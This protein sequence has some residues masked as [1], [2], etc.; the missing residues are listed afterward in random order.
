MNV[1]L[2]E[3]GFCLTVGPDHSDL[4]YGVDVL[5]LTHVLLNSPPVFHV[6]CPSAAPNIVFVLHA[7]HLG[8]FL[9]IGNGRA[10]TNL[11]DHTE[12]PY[13]VHV[14]DNLSRL[15]GKDVLGSALKECVTLQS[16][17]NKLWHDEQWQPWRVFSLEGEEDTPQLVAFLVKLLDNF[18]VDKL[19]ADEPV[20]LAKGYEPRHMVFFYLAQFLAARLACELPPESLA[21]IMSVASA[22][23][24]EYNFLESMFAATLLKPMFLPVR[25]RGVLVYSLFRGFHLSQGTDCTPPDTGFRWNAP[26]MA[27]RFDP[28]GWFGEEGNRRDLW[29]YAPQMGDR[30]KTLDTGANVATKVFGGVDPERGLNLLICKYLLS[31]HMMAHLQCVVFATMRNMLPCRHNSQCGDLHVVDGS[32]LK[33]RNAVLAQIKP[34]YESIKSARSPTVLLCTG[35][36]FGCDQEPCWGKVCT[37]NASLR[38]PYG[39]QWSKPWAPKSNQAPNTVVVEMSMSKSTYM[40]DMIDISLDT[41]SGRDALKRNICTLVDAPYNWQDKLK[42]F[43][44]PETHLGM[45]LRYSPFNE[46]EFTEVGNVLNPQE[47][48]SKFDVKF[49]KHDLDKDLTYLV[50]GTNGNMPMCH[51]TLALSIRQ[52]VAF[53]MGYFSAEM[54]RLLYGQDELN[55]D[56]LCSNILRLSTQLTPKGNSTEI[57][58]TMLNFRAG[59]PFKIKGK[60]FPLRFSVCQE[61]QLDDLEWLSKDPQSLPD[62]LRGTLQYLGDTQ[63]KVATVLKENPKLTY[64]RIKFTSA[65]VNTPVRSLFANKPALLLAPMIVNST[66]WN[67]TDPSLPTPHGCMRFAKRHERSGGTKKEGFYRIDLLNNDCINED[68]CAGHDADDSREPEEVTLEQMLAKVVEEASRNIVHRCKVSRLNTLFPTLTKEVYDALVAMMRDRGVTLV[69]NVSPFYTLNSAQALKRPAQYVSGGAPEKQPRGSANLHANEDT[70][71]G[72]GSQSSS[73]EGEGPF[74]PRANFSQ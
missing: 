67:F 3:E 10:S 48:T 39:N 59:D 69:E 70:E 37:G 13:E 45:Y 19:S 35:T 23:F 21:M 38:A 27:E 49:H 40:S 5:P 43:R 36:G 26:D 7:E 61:V 4:K 50:L 29:R 34:L 64:T 57:M 28:K 11:T 17:E 41:T 44:K 58:N 52:A 60:A 6:Y 46:T 15:Q 14:W 18:T 24:L 1:C 73:E 2:P 9:N 53:S 62:K 47:H 65:G 32:A 30:A 71:D 55:L 25:V 16:T 12:R 72:Q 63:R 56:L 66:L 68:A 42:A 74:R 8:H 20:P 31:D 22:P 54:G 33:M 51:V